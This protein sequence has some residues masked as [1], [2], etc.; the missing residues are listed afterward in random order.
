MDKQ[1]KELKDVMQGYLEEAKEDGKKLYLLH[2]QGKLFDEWFYAQ[3]NE[4]EKIEDAYWLDELDYYDFEYFD[5]LK[6]MVQ[7]EKHGFD[8]A[9]D[10]LCDKCMLVDI[11][12]REKYGQELLDLI[13]GEL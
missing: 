2:Y 11:D 1:E 3:V 13:A 7:C 8:V 10:K 9:C 6:M 4:D 12:D 5:G